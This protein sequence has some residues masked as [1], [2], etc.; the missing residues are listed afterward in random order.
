MIGVG[1]VVLGPTDKMYVNAVLDSGRLSY[2]PWSRLFEANWAALHNRKHAVF[3]NS[4][5]SALQVGLHAMKL[6]F[7]WKD[8]DEVL[9]PATTFVASVNTI[10]DNG[11]KPLLVDVHPETFL[12]NTWHVGKLLA[13]REAGGEKQPVAVM[14]VH[15]Y[16]SVVPRD[17]HK[18]AKA[19][20]VRVIADSCET[21]VSRGCADGDV[22]CFS[23]Y[24]CHHVTTGI[25]GFATTDDD[26]LAVLLRSLANHGRDG[27]FFDREAKGKEL[28]SRRF[29]FTH[30]G[31]S[32][33]ATELEA[34]LGCA[35]LERLPEQ[36]E[37]R[38]SNVEHL[39]RELR[40]LPLLFPSLTENPHWM[41]LPML[42]PRRDELCEHLEANGVETR[43]LLPL[44]NQPCY[45]GL[46]TEANYPI[47]EQIN[48]EGFYVGCHPGLTQNDLDT[49]VDAFR[50]FSW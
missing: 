14:P 37:Q 26:D 21:V 7:G 32:Y 45:E 12:L 8:G 1:D 18:M 41:F 3:M 13:H 50:S 34:A 46:F 49:I 42:S 17:L 22:S 30:R 36:L 31:Y 24:A 38:A 11:L 10:L 19:F 43:Q 5:T 40:G 15:L 20:G 29:A 25:G 27:I 2:G 47:A 39:L 4:G 23:T 28:I 6:H 33:R 48:R 44:T 16:G 35:Q 9:V